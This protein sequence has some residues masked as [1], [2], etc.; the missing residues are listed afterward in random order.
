MVRTT[1]HVFRCSGSIWNSYRLSLLCLK[2]NHSVQ[3]ISKAV[4]VS[5]SVTGSSVL[6]RGWHVHMAGDH[7]RNDARVHSETFACI[8]QTFMLR[9]SADC[10]SFWKFFWNNLHSHDGCL[11][12][13]SSL[14]QLSTF[15]CFLV[16]FVC[17]ICFFAYSLSTVILIIYVRHTSWPL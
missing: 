6:N 5:P 12:I 3:N 15:F 4:S 2:C 1:Q 14:P 7:V 8:G 9:T 11:N 10:C 13:R 17:C 16:M